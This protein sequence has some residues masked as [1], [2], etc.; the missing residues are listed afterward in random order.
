[1]IRNLYAMN[2]YDN[3]LELEFCC[4]GSC[5]LIKNKYQTSEK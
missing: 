1:M 4:Q 2:E 5:T 3:I